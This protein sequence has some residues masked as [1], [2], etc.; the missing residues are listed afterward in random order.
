[1][2]VA[3]Q[4]AFDPKGKTF[5][6]RLDAMIQDASTTHGLTIRKDSGRTAEWQQKLHI[7]HMFLYNKYASTTP[8]K[9][10]AGKRTIAWSHISDPKV[11]WSTVQFSE[12]L[13]TKTGVFPVKEGNAWKKDSEPD[14]AKTEERAKALLKSEGVGNNGEAMVSS[15]LK[16]C[17]EPCKCGAERSKH[18]DDLAA[19]LNSGDLTLLEGK[20]KTAKTGSLDDYLKKFGLNRPLVNHAT[21]PEK[22]HVEST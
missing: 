1:M 7:A 17:G 3:T 9:T 15:G 16:P 14:K 12:I 20:L 6:Q 10:E 19:D 5:K 18:L 22:W 2:S 8:A 4:T 21:S 13:R 11:F